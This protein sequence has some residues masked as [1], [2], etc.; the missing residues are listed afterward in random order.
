MRQALQFPIENPDWG[1]GQLEVTFEPLAIPPRHDLVSSVFGWVFQGN[2]MLLIRRREH[3]WELPGGC[4]KPGE[5]FRGTLD[6]AV[7]EAGGVRLDMARFIGAM[8]V[9]NHG[10]HDPY[11]YPV[12]YRPCFI[13]EVREMLPFTAEIEAADRMLIEP[14]LVPRM[15]RNWSPLMDQMLAFARAVRS[16]SRVEAPV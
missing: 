13:T 10:P 3:G 4:R 1:N 9:T 8:R 2:E 14:E 15:V 16:P 5:T 12:S 11:A 7:W 6:R